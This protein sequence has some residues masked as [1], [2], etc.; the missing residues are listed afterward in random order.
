[1]PL[2]TAQ[3]TQKKVLILSSGRGR[4]SINQ[5]EASLRA[6]FSGPVNF[7]IVDLDE[8]PFEQE[9]FRGAYEENLAEGLQKG[10]SGERLDLVVSVMTWPLQFAVQYRDKIFP[11]VPIVFMSTS[12]PLPE[13]IWPRVTGVESADGI[14]ETID[15]A[16]RFHPDTQAVAVIGAALPN[17]P[18]ARAGS[19]QEW[20]SAEHSELL[21]HRDKVR[22]IDLLGPVKPELLQRVAELPPD[23]VVLFQLYP[24]DSD[25]PAFGAL[26]VLAD[27]AQRFPTYSFLPHITI[28]RGGVAGVSYDSTKDAVLAGELAARVL[29]GERA[30]DIPVVQNSDVV[31]SVDW[32]QLRRW[33]IPES[34]L[35][36]GARVL[37]RE[38]T[39]WEQGRK[40]F[41]TAIA[42]IFIQSLLIFGLF[43]QRT[44][45]RKAE[46]KLGESE[47]KFSKAFRQS[48]FAVTIVDAKDDRYID[49]NQT[50]EVQ[51]GWKR[52]EVIG[53]TPLA[54]NL[55]ADPDQRITFMRDLFEKGNVRDLEVT[56]RRK[57]GQIRTSLGSAELIEVNGEMCALSVIADITERKLAEEALSGMS[58]KLIEAHEEERT[59][60]A[61][62]LH[63]DINQRL[64]LLAVNLGTLTEKLPASTVEVK[65]RIRKEQELVSELGRD[66]QA[67]SHRLH[68]SKL[69]YL[70]LAAAASTLCRELS[71]Q[72]EVEIDFHPDGIPK[73]LPPEISLCLFR[74]MQEAL[75]NAIKHSG[76]RNFEVRLDSA[77]NEIRLSVRDSGIGFDLDEAMKGRGV[78]LSSMRERLKLVGG[79]FSIESR[80]QHGTT[81]HARVSLSPKMKSASAGEQKI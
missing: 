74:V 24:V 64:A 32:R 60:I 45:R 56:F 19:D 51:T 7:S 75:Q 31:V 72:Q 46:L 29:S 62:E 77:L 68:S 43:W 50:F 33:N 44:R 22:E 39:L 40:Y 76:S 38:P 20:Y 16:L 63:D 73:Q 79:E 26:D 11:G 2:A 80:P 17:H 53:R 58:R 37:Y 28:G 25:Q 18:G 4:V 78:G 8:P 61:R 59:W 67:L 9:S 49:V 15:L 23:T 55:W 14:R 34:A 6:H 1:M 70:G 71:D 65:R 69:E 42:V 27:V 21:R 12:T 47:E 13:K 52:D 54:I 36:Q 5:M 66:V 48:P 57:D 3:T 41:L 81:I 30:D 10:F 35:P